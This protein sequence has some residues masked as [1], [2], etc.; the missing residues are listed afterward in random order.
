MRLMQGGQR[1][2]GFQHLEHRLIHLNGLGV[3]HAAVHHPVTDAD[4]PIARQL[5]AQMV[6]QMVER[7][8][9]TQLRPVVED[10]SAFI[11]TVGRLRNKTRR[12]VEPFDSARTSGSRVSLRSTNSENLMLDEP[13]SRTTMALQR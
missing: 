12:G 4:Q 3:G 8:V 9:V 5:R 13:V 10:F 7:T 1:D 11:C 6:D 2:E